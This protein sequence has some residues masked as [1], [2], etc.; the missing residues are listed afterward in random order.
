[1]NRDDLITLIADAR[2]RRLS[3]PEIADAILA[4]A[5]TDAT[6][7]KA[8]SHPA[9]GGI[10]RLLRRD[11]SLSPVAA[12]RELEQTV[13]AVA[14]HF[15]QLNKLGFIEIC[16]EIPRRGA[17]EHVYRLCTPPAAWSAQAAA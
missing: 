11:G 13:G 3:N 2:R 4:L 5:E 12:A 16:D 7:A 8:L 14:Y 10:L 1:M 6:W 15:R 9:R 17:T